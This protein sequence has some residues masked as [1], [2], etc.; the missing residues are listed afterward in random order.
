M[1]DGE[2]FTLATGRVNP[3]CSIKQERVSMSA[4][5]PSR[6]DHFSV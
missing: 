6:Q 2:L 5:H 1:V 4:A 3:G